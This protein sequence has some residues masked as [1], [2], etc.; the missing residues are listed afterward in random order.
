MF[1]KC[2]TFFFCFVFPTPSPIL[3]PGVSKSSLPG[4]KYRTEIVFK[5]TFMK[6]NDLLMISCDYF[7]P[8]LS[9]ASVKVPFWVE[10]KV[11]NKRSTK[12]ITSLMHPLCIM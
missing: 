10:N 8:S 12:K 1:K 5:M 2:V 6:I 9:P 7:P 3:I 4:E 11:K